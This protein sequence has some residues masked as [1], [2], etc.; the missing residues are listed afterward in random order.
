L[1]TYVTQV[2]VTPASL[3]FR[4]VPN[5]FY[6]GEGQKNLNFTIVPMG[7][8]SILMLILIDLPTEIRELLGYITQVLLANTCISFGTFPNFTGGVKSQFLTRFF[9]QNS[10]LV[11]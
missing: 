4:A 6:S 9:K 7:A 8:F 3:S 1:S 5:F 11:I 10:Q 2:L